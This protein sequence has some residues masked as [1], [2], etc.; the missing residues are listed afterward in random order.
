MIR[1]ALLGLLAPGLAHAQSVAVL[2]A[3]NVATVNQDVVDL[4][5]CSGEFESVDGWD[6]VAATPTLADLQFHHAVLV[7]NDRALPNAAALGDVL[8][9]Y[10]DAGGGVVLGYGP[11]VQGTQLA[12]R[13]VTGGYLPVSVGTASTPGANLGFAIRPEHYWLPG[14]AGHPLVYGVNTFDGGTA[15]QQAAGLVPTASAIVV[16]DWSSGQPLVVTTDPA[17]LTQG[18]VVAL[19]FFTA[20]DESKASSWAAATDG[21]NMLSNALVW[22]Q[23][24]VRPEVCV[25]DDVLQDFNCNGTDIA[26]EPPIDPFLDADCDD[27]DPYTGEPALSNDYYFDVFSH[28]CKYFV[29]DQDI[30][31]NEGQTPIMGDLLVGFDADAGVGTVEV[32][33]DAGVVVGTNTLQCDNCPLDYNP[34]Q[35]DRDCDNKGDLC[36]NCLIIPN[37]DQANEDED[38][39]GDACDNC[40]DVANDDQVNS[41]EDSF[42]DACDN[43]DFLENE[44]Q[45]NGDGIDCPMDPYGV[46]TPDSLGDACDNCPLHCNEDQRDGDGDL[47]GDACDNCRTEPNPDQADVDQDGIGDACDICPDVATTA[48][49]P[50]GDGD[51]AGDSCDVCPGLADDQADMDVDGLGDACD[52]C[53]TFYNDTQ[54]DADGDTV[55]D[56]CD[57]CPN[58][59]NPLQ[60]DGDADAVGDV[61]DS[62]PVIGNPREEDGLQP[63]RDRDNVGDPCDLCPEVIST[64]NGDDDADGF[65]D[66]CDNCPIDPNADQL[67]EDGDGAGDLCDRIAIR[68][69]GTVGCATSGQVPVG[70]LGLGLALL[71][72]RRRR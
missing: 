23:R 65:G 15:S 26:D 10:V 53:P 13:L 3:V 6:L 67:D 9:D 34:D 66:E 58:A 5:Q 7:W 39:V 44:D 12:G 29:A 11:L 2:G 45:L 50:D 33:D 14:E 71:S 37:V 47:A 43:C 28:G 60:E 8:A 31:L 36:D 1:M 57:S 19:N 41:D 61:C 63:D 42:G 16:A 21:A 70:L 17:D 62:C 68:G 48:D 30:D 55:G 20:S 32:T 64:A 49:E 56:S 35:A 51:G 18:R 72:L 69:G 24:A 22:A 4:V 46:V 40:F 25:N 38:C 59:V 27:F 52:N 54:G